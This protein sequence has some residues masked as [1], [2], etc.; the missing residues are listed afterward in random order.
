MA[1]SKY[2]YE[3]HLTTLKHL[4]KLSEV[5]LRCQECG[6]IFTKKT[7]CYRHKRNKCSSGISTHNEDDIYTDFE[8]TYDTDHYTNCVFKKYENGLDAGLK[9][10]NHINKSIENQQ[11][12]MGLE[13][14]K[15]GK[16][17]FDSRLENLEAK[18]ENLET[19]HNLSLIKSE[20]ETQ[21]Q[22]LNSYQNNQNNQHNQYQYVNPVINNIKN[23]NEGDK[24]INFNG[25]NNQIISKK[26]RLNMYFGNTIDIDTFTENYKNNP[27]YQLTF[28]ETRILL[29]NA[30][31]CGMASYGN[32][33]FNYLQKKYQMQVEDLL[34]EDVQYDKEVMPFIATDT[35]LRSHYEKTPQGWLPVTNTEKLKKLVVISNDQVYKHHK[36]FIKMTYRQKE[37][38]ANTLLKRS[39]YHLVEMKSKALEGIPKESRMCI[40]DL[41]HNLNTNLNTNQ[42]CLD[43][44]LFN[45]QN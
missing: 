4:K 43:H 39:D 16:K 22:I 25:N 3:R 21:K 19:R 17:I 26:E 12:K 5:G 18:I 11:L 38:A 37:T 10:I 45:L 44:L 8:G 34:G 20:L 33:L 27:I 41:S 28:E 13:I 7:N 30:E 23:I 6:A 32:G 29:E 15:M 9:G 1:K 24:T 42:S 36:K 40:T 2:H 31:T 35:N 14:E